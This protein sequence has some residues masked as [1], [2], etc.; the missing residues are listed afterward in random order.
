MRFAKLFAAL[1]F[2]A[3]IGPA[4]AQNLKGNN[5]SGAIASTNTFQLVF[6]GAAQDNS[7]CA[8]QNTGTHTEYVYP[9]IVANATVGK[10]LQLAPGQPLNCGPGDLT[11]SNQWSITGTAGDTYYAERW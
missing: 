8:I 1:V 6:S 10:A 11:L 5:Y 4:A 9:D 3:I 7:G 2:A